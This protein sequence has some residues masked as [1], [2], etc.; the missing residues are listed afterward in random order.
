MSWSG[1]ALA[2]DPLVSSACSGQGARSKLVAGGFVMDH[3]TG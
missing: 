3:G 1:A 2:D